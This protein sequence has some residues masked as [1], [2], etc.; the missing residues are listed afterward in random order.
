MFWRCLM[1][2][3]Q[4]KIYWHE[5]Y[6]VTQLAHNLVSKVIKFNS[7]WTEQV[8]RTEWL[9][10]LQTNIFMRPPTPHWKKTCE[11]HYYSSFQILIFQKIGFV[12]LCWPVCSGTGALF[13]TGWIQW[14]DERN[15]VDVSH[16]IQ[17]RWASVPNY[18]HTRC[19]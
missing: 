2:L 4:K 7:R 3:N 11:W 10:G 14:E 12:W 8:N 16:R 19:R 13:K 17:R 9:K 15:C 6:K 1:E 5:S 18:K